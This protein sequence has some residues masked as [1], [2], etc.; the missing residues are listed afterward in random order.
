M[1]PI[2][3]LIGLIGKAKSR[4]VNKDKQQEDVLRVPS[5]YYDLYEDAGPGTTNSHF[6]YFKRVRASQVERFSSEASKLLIRLHKILNVTG[7]ESK[8]R[9]LLKSPESYYHHVIL[10][11]YFLICCV[12]EFLAHE[13]EIVQWMEEKHVPRCPDCAQSFNIL[14]RKH[15]CRLWYVKR[16]LKVFIIYTYISGKEIAISVLIFSWYDWWVLFTSL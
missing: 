5:K 9:G 16:T 13:Q 3:I 4:L 2:S 11:N 8:R 12:P 15:H 7:D 10:L 1:T 14:L 6:E